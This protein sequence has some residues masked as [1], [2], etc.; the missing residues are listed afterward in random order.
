MKVAHTCV[1]VPI[2]VTTNLATLTSRR[3]GSVGVPPGA[4]HPRPAD[5]ERLQGPALQPGHE[6]NKIKKIANIDNNVRR[7]TSVEKV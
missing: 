3:A 1:I 5:A 6:P 2:S 4:P 7:L